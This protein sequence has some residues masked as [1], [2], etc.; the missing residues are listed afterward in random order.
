MQLGALAAHEAAA[1]LRRGTCWFWLVAPTALVPWIIRWGVLCFERSAEELRALRSVQD[2]GRYSS[3][4][5]EWQCDRVGAI[6][7][8]IPVN[9]PASA[10]FPTGGDR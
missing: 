5:L 7:W 10:L 9:S 2:K 4:G 8:L 1:K 3:A 6:H